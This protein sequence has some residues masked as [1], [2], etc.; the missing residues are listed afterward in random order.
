MKKLW[1]QRGLVLRLEWASTEKAL[2]FCGVEINQHDYA[3]EILDRWKVDRSS[4]FPNFRVNEAD[5]EA[6]DS[7]SPSVLKEAQALAGGLLW[8]STRTR[9]DLAFGVS[10]M[11]RL[12]SKNAQKALEVGHTSR[13]ILEILT[14]S[15]TS[16][17]MDG[18]RGT[19]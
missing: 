16:R 13:P 11:S 15:G 7:I 8:L 14:T 1:S 5:F 2:K 17:T 10:A 12:M 6:V 19:N 4:D 3:Q 18:V 9:P